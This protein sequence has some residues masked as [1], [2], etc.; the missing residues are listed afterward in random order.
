MSMTHTEGWDFLNN[1]LHGN[2]Q[3]FTDWAGSVTG[4]FQEINSKDGIDPTKFLNMLTYMQ[5]MGASVET[6][7]GNFA[8]WGD[9]MV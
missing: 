4:A 7:G 9:L 8:S 1:K 5:Q 2:A 3:N 6:L